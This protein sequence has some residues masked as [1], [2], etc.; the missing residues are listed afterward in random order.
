MDIELKK[1]LS[2]IAGTI[3]GLSIDG[4]QKAN[5]GH[6]GL[7]LGCAD[8]AA[9]LWGYYLR[10]NPK[11]PKWVNR[12]RFILSAGHGSM[13]LYSALHLSGYNL[14]IDDLKNFRQLHSKTP[15][16]PEYRETDGV[17]TTTGP[18]GQ[19]VANAV[20]IA[21]GLKMLQTKFN[22]DSKPLLTNKVFTLA[23]DGCIMEGISSEASSLAGH[24][25]LDNFVL[26]YDSNKICLDGDLSECCSE[27]TKARYEAY[28]FDTFEVDGHDF[29]AL[30][31]VFTKIRE[32]Q[33]KPVLIVMHTVI[34][35]GSP[36]RQGSHKAHGEPLGPDELILTKQSLGLP[37]E[38]FYVPQSVNTYFDK[39]QI[40]NQALED[41]WN[42]KFSEWKK[43]HSE[44]AVEW[45]TMFSKK[46]PSDLESIIRNIPMKETQ[47]G[48]AAANDIINALAPIIP[49]LIGGS[50]DLSGS[51]KTMIKKMDIV[52]PHIF[53]GRNIKFGVREF[54]MSAMANGL[55]LTDMFLPFI[56]T[57]LTFSDY[58]RNAIRLASLMKLHVIYQF[59]HDSIFLGED[60]PTH[61]PVEHY[62]ALRAIPNL[63][64][65]R[66]ADN[67]E[68]KMGWLAALLYEGP[69]AFA[70][71]R[72]NLSPVPGTDVPY[73]E[74][75]ARGAYIVKKESAKE[76][77]YTLYASGSEL[78]L[79]FDVAV[80]LEKRGRAT[81][82]VSVPC[83][84]LF[85]K[86][87]DAYKETIV[88]GN[89]GKRVSIEAGVSLGWHRFIGLDGIAIA[90]DSFGA[91]APASVLAKEFG[92]TVESILERL[93]STCC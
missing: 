42:S 44:L 55:A 36:N 28:G 48:R 92:F 79:A 16:H 31:Q 2:K 26:I 69:T 83:F 40:Q 45:D 57:F 46:L 54:A 61:Q 90:Q 30:D 32:D 33:K 84:A 56:G 15:G 1:S 51:D 27:N 43:T 68:A 12:D 11:N 87:S 3:R 93:L 80:E 35:R 9:Y 88:G 34:G 67:M 72:Q 82:V 5:S 74:G 62:A 20:G 4:V 66:P 6:P 52:K 78:Q 7:P 50:A 64:F 91:S 18:L 63:H 24:L 17:E 77:Q 19:G 29:E 22:G 86:Q 13:L 38:D 49:Q 76:P 47:A 53:K 39:K 21:L 58:M 89:L 73:E 60:G 75:V 70:F 71:T 8:L 81:R 85:E 59:T 65:I 23:G 41:D 25:G 10:Y 14:S 37:L